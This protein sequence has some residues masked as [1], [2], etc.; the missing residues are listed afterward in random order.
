MT[1]AEVFAVLGKPHE[2]LCSGFYCP[3]WYFD[4][5]SYVSFTDMGA[6][7]RLR[8]RPTPCTSKPCVRRWAS[9]PPPAA[10]SVDE[11]TDG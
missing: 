2:D 4:D 5:G 9:Q 8:L 3:V 11:Q 10:G 1:A 7:Q 6:N